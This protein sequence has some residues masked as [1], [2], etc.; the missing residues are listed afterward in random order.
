MNTCRLSHPLATLAVAGLTTVLVAACGGAKKPPSPSVTG[1]GSKNSAVASAYHYADCMR[2]H[3]VSS[4]QDPHVHQS[5]N[6]MS[7]GFRVDP[8]I[9]GSPNFKSAQRACAH[10]LPGLSN[11]PTPAQTRAREQAIL[12]FASC[13][14]HHGFPKFPDP[15]SQGRLTPTMLSKAGIDLQ[16]PAIK[17]AADACVSVTHGIISRADVNQAISGGQPGGGSQG[18]PAGG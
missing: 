11:G 12:A 4:F 3:G 8:Q 10:I 16:Q 9:T 5:G 6:S 7:V 17:P 1:H 18:S 13:M 14:R 15:T 2:S